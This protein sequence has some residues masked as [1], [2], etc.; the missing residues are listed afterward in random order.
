MV[1]PALMTNAVQNIEQSSSSENTIFL[2]DL[3]VLEKQCAQK[4]SLKRIFFLLSHGILYTS[5][6]EFGMQGSEC[7]SDE[8]LATR[9]RRILCGGK[10]ASL[11]YKGFLKYGNIMIL[12]SS[13]EETVIL[14]RSDKPKEYHLVFESALEA[15]RFQSVISEIKSDL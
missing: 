1:F 6:S 4:R 10:K 3:F 11:E 13:N 12:P 15:R 14:S 9:C 8:N 5:R 2:I 7:S